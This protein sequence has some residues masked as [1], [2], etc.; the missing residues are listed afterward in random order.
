LTELVDNQVPDVA[1]DVTNWVT[2]VED[3]LVR[4]QIAIELLNREAGVAPE[5]KQLMDELRARVRRL[6][7]EAPNAQSVQTW[8]RA[9][10]AAARGSPKFINHA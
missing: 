4:I 8:L 1:S 10:S 2:E 7:V 3:L 9:M 5:V 6:R